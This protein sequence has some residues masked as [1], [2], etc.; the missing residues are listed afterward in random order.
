MPLLL[1]LGALLI[2]GAATG[3]LVFK[4]VADETQETVNRTGPSLVLLG[5]GA[6]GV[7]AAWRALMSRN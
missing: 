4:T 5:L 1:A 6:F 7:W 2:A 3:G